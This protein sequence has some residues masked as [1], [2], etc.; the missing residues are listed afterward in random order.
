VVAVFVNNPTSL[1]QL[2][3]YIDGVQQ[4]L[5]QRVGTTLL[6]RAVSSSARIS[7]WPPDSNYRFTGY[8]DEFA[9]FNRALTASEVAAQFNGR[10]SAN[11][12]GIITGQNTNNSLVGY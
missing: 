5:T 6:T 12:T 1:S 7:G 9:F 8:L 11:Y 2:Q 3:L 10:S 4:T